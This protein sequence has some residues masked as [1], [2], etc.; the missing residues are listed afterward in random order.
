MN[1]HVYDTRK[2]D[3]GAM[4]AAV[5]RAYGGLGALAVENL[6][7]EGA[8]RLSEDYD[9]GCWAFVTSED[10]NQGF[11]YPLDK[12]HYAVECIGNYYRNETMPAAS[13]GAALTLQVVNEL[14][15]AAAGQGAETAAAEFSE[16]YHQLRDFVFD[17]A[18]AHPD[19]LDGAEIAA[20]ID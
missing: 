16:K 18:E 9:G 19:F 7:Y 14:A 17:L 1:Y 3:A 13:F 6:L 5:T 10:G 2:T 4:I 12:L 8:R 15:W 11:W 20:F